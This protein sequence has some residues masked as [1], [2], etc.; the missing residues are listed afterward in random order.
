MIEVLQRMLRPRVVQIPLFPLK[1][2]LFPGGVL[3]LK[4]FEQRYIDMTKDCLREQKPF[5][6]C[7]ITGG[8][9]VG[10]AAEFADIGTL[11]NI[12]DWDMPQLGILHLTTHG[13][14]RFQVN[15]RT[16]EADGLNVAEVSLLEAE[17]KHEV[18]AEYAQLVRLLELLIERIGDSH[19]P[20]EKR[21][22][23]ASWVS[24]RLAE[25]LPLKL[26]IKQNMLEIND[27]TIRMK[28]LAQFMKQQGLV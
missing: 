19:F 21:F 4:V 27:S 16:V 22:D 12:D 28:V 15:S 24:Y 18:A 3:P 5:G 25:I 1:A 10:A 11:S 6:V 20:A 17:P 2:V 8:E 7:M 23:D 13:G 9:E 14:Q 26:S